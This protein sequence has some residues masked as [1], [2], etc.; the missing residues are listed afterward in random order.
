MKKNKYWKFDIGNLKLEIPAPQAGFT[1]VE[2]LI[3][4]GVFSI[5]LVALS[6]VF[7]SIAE[8]QLESKSTSDVDQD[9]RYILAKL[10]HD[11]HNA[12]AIV[13]PVALGTAS[14]SL[15]ITL[16]SINYT[17]SLSNGKLQVTDG[18][19]TYDLNSVGTTVSGVTFTRIGSGTNNDTIQVDYVVTSTTQR[20]NGAETRS[21]QTTLA[22]Q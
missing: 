15:Q 6:G 1:I 10:T 21:Y 5:L 16:N 13:A 2:L 18:T 12:S 17:Y 8:V 20:P 4:M 9:G 7:T 3:Y 11:M 14:T 22:I 19:D